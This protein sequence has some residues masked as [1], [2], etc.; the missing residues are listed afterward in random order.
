MLCQQ[1]RRLHFFSRHSRSSFGEPRKTRKARRIV[2]RKKLSTDCADF[3]RFIMSHLGISN[4]RK[5]AQSVDETLWFRAAW[6]AR[7][8]EC[9]RLAPREEVCAFR[10]QQTRESRDTRAWSS[11][12]SSLEPAREVTA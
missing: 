4:L 3:H 6:R 9:S 12:D 10:A 11:L 5:S 7:W 8:H 1:V 2:R